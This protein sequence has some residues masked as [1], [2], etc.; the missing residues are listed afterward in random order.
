MNFH[1]EKSNLDMDYVKF[2][3]FYVLKYFLLCI[4]PLNGCW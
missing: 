2:G 1:W 3:N 4:P